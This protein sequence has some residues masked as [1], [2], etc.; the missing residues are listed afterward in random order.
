[1]SDSE[2]N[3]SD[4]LTVA[5]DAFEE[6]IFDDERE[7]FE[8]L[9]ENDDV[10]EMEIEI[11]EETKSVSENTFSGGVV[12]SD[13]SD[14]LNFLRS[15]KNK[16][17]QAQKQDQSNKIDYSQLYKD[18]VSKKLETNLITIDI[19]TVEQLQEYHH[20]CMLTKYEVPRLVMFCKQYF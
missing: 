15:Q 1:M 6:D 3:S 19:K 16:M 10:K 12:K 18:N 8:N 20:L 5:S 2:D 4:T 17:Q 7:D 11:E 9:K 14:I 13:G